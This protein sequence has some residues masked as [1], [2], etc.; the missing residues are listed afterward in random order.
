M[1][2]QENGHH[3]GVA[4]DD[5]HSATNG[6]FYICKRPPDLPGCSPSSLEGDSRS[7]KNKTDEESDSNGNNNNDN[8]YNYNKNNNRSDNDADEQW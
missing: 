8:N 5:I 1:G 3:R 2:F 7:P 6:N 4:L